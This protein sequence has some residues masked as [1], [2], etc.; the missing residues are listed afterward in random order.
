MAEINEK[1]SNCTIRLLAVAS[2]AA[3]CIK[4]DNN[5]DP[6][7]KSYNEVL[8]DIS[9][10]GY[11]ITRSIAPINSLGTGTTPLAAVC[12]SPKDD[13]QS[14]IIISYRGTRV[15]GD[16]ISNV[17]LGTTGVV[18]KLFRDEAYNFYQKIREENPNR[19]IILTGHSL[20]GHLAHYVATKA[21]NTDYNLV[22]NPLIQVRTFN[23]APLNT[24]H[25]AVFGNNQGLLAQFVNYRLSSDIVS[26][27]PMQE[28]PGNTFAFPCAKNLVDA[29]LIGTISK[30]LPEEI[31]NQRV[32]GSSE[33]DKNNNLLIEMIN[34]VKGGYQC[35]VNGQFFSKFRAGATNL[36]AMEE[37]FPDVI[38]AIE[39]RD[40]TGA[41]QKLT[42]I[43]GKLQGEVSKDIIDVLKKST[44]A[45][46]QSCM[47]CPSHTQAQQNWK[48]TMQ[49]F[50]MADVSEKKE[51]AQKNVNASLKGQ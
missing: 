42:E 28:Y 26:D 27:L 18:E 23:T 3:Y 6:N 13:P 12:L 43:D 1:G 19:Q 10:H 24:T 47:L 11:E 29:H 48:S 41:I 40:Y 31:L 34:G 7:Y 25:S 17:V 38:K 44:A 16:V 50:R 37:G 39:R 5:I 30:S 8:T 33:F 9:T 14:P 51:E 49:S 4:K 21:Y 22:S 46:E 20:G 2:K 15:A 36:K 32:G 35:H 45:I